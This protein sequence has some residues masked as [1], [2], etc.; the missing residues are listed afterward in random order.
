MS[1][2]SQ[3][4]EIINYYEKWGAK[5]LTRE[6]YNKDFYL[7]QHPSNIAIIGATGYGKTNILINLIAKS[8]CFSNIF[9]FTGSTPKEFL[10]DKLKEL[11]DDKFEAFESLEELKEFV[12][13]T[14][15]L[16]ESQVLVIIDDF[17][18]QKKMHPVISHFLT[19]SRKSCDGGCSVVLLAQS[20]FEL[21]KTMRLQCKYFV[22]MGG[23]DKRE[24][25]AI[26][27]RFSCCDCSIDQIE[28]MYIESTKGK[29]VTDFF[30]IDMKTKF[31]NL[32]FRKG[33][34]DNWVINQTE[35]GEFDG[36]A[37]EQE[38]ESLQTKKE[39]LRQLTEDSDD[40]GDPRDE[41]MYEEVV[42]LRTKVGQGQAPPAPELEK[43]FKKR[44][45]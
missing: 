40:E 26:T 37:K 4:R 22:L 31:D 20:F 39:K 13:K 2:T 8:D 17:I 16:K 25:R 34:Y 12:G 3:S 1:R 36:L 6:Y 23:L 18:L 10:Y 21:E 45:R 35:R 30:M 44:F 11:L 29:D 41:D 9:L 28:E 38:I 32:K 33:F 14:K 19:F 7:P 24:L 5:P 27:G 15:D 43:R 42:V